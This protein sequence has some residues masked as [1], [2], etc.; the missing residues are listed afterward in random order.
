MTKISDS[1]AQSTEPRAATRRGLLF[2]AGAAA[3]GATALALASRSPGVE[4]IA[5]A[6]L[7]APENG[8]GYRVTD[9][10]KHYY[11]TTLI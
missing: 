3:A 1:A 7:P 4:A 6:E 8:G 2:G 5:Q 10:V 9:H 11:A